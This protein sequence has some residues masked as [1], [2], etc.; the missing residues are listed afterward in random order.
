MLKGNRAILLGILLLLLGCGKEERPLSAGTIGVEEGRRLDAVKAPAQAP[1]AVPKAGAGPVAELS[2]AQLASF[3][4]RP[5]DPYAEN[6][7]P[8]K[9][10]IPAPIR[11]LDGR[12]VSLEGYM[13]PIR[14]RGNRVETFSL[15][16]FIG[17]CCF[18]RLPRMNESVEVS[19]APGET[20][21]YIP[22]GVILVT[23]RFSVGEEKD[24]YGYVTSIYR[25]VGESVE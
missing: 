2:F 7:V 13:V 9:E 4:Y 18:G 6:P 21:E 12:R 22:H 1:A 24:E 16:R 14:T 11:A 3:V 8:T 19:L 5:P 20:A 10:Q 15:S 17:G 25:M 23:G